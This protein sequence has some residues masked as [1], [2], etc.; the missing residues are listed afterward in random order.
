LPWKITALRKDLRGSECAL[1]AAQVDEVLLVRTIFFKQGSSENISG[2][3]ERVTFFNSE[4]EEEEESGCL[5]ACLVV[6]LRQRRSGFAG[7]A[8][9]RRDGGVY[10]HRSD[11]VQFLCSLSFLF[12]SKNEYRGRRSM[13]TIYPGVRR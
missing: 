8:F 7:L 10:G 3:I 12:N 5:P 9:A 11:E 1:P 6:S 4:E 13:L 2:L